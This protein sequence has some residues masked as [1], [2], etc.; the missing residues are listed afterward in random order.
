MTA[1]TETPVTTPAP[2]PVATPVPRLARSPSAETGAGTGAEAELLFRRAYPQLAGWVRRLVDD[3][4]EIA[5]E[6]A[7]EAFVRLLSRSARVDC[8]QS[9][10]YV[11]AANLIRDHWR[12]VRRERWGISQV[13]AVAAAEPTVNPAQDV[14]VRDLIGSLSPRLRDPFLLYY[15]GG[16]QIRD[17]AALL[18]RPEGTVKA[19]LFAARAKLKAAL[20]NPAPD[21]RSWRVGAWQDVD[22]EFVARWVGHAAPLE[23]LELPSVPRFEPAA[24]ELRDVRGCLVEVVN[25]QVKVNPVLAVLGVGHPLEPDREAVFC[26]RQDEEFPVA[27]LGVHGYGEQAAPEAGQRGRIGGVDH[28]VAHSCLGGS[29]GVPRFFR[30]R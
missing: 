10:L 29:H 18:R 4:E 26:R 15:Y 12:K 19:D 27:D 13:T 22:V 28:Q 2:R 21:P 14:D 17:V 6:I 30:S 20:A 16:F 9:Y 3:D 8:P 5:H 11:I 24:A 25:Y 7:S 1:W 23:A